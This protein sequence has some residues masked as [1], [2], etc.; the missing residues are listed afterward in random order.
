MASI[1]LRLA[2]PTSDYSWYVRE[3]AAGAAYANGVAT[4]Q[5]TGALPADATGTYS[6]GMEGYVNAVLNPGTKK[7][8]TYRDAG[9]NVQKFLAVTGDVVQRRT[10]VA[11]EKCNKCHDKLQ[12]HGNNRNDPQYCVGCHNAVTT[13]VARRPAAA[14]QPQGIH[15]KLMIHR[16]H[17][18]EELESDFTVYGFGNRAINFN[19]VR[20]PGDR[21]DCTTCHVG[22]SYTLPI[23]SSALPTVNPQGFWSPMA[24]SAAACLGCHDGVDAAAHAFTNTATFGE[25]C[26]VCHE[27][28][29]EFAVSKVHAR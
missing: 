23:A 22:T 26:P 1:A 28:G 21:R 6:V 17:T 16:I 15:F 5:F 2:G 9:D 25:A 4:Y 27:E 7:E 12:L 24:P 3:S 11:L 10:V 19:E 14:G 13:D 29:A 8:F 18:G 20:F